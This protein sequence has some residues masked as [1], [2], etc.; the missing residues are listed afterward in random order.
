MLTSHLIMRINAKLS[1]SIQGL[2]EEALRL[3][4]AHTWPGNVRELE[5]TLTRAAALARGTILDKSLIELETAP[6]MPTNA[7]Q[8]QS[9]LK[10][11][12]EL[13]KEHVLAVLAQTHGHRGKACDILGISRP[14]LERRIK[15]YGYTS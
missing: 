6:H 12:E 14:A 10:S 4:K 8:Q 11:L 5:N 1:K 2:D 15:K 13:E 9:A 7:A 3:L